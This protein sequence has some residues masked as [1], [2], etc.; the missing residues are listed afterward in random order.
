ME[1]RSILDERWGKKVIDA[2]KGFISNPKNLGPKISQK[3]V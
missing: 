3:F 2:L 1:M